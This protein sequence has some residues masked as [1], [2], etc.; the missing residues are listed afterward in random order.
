MHQHATSKRRVKPRGR[1]RRMQVPFIENFSPP[2]NFTF[3]PSEIKLIGYG[4]KS[5]DK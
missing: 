5:R 1:R 3:A 2:E 4:I